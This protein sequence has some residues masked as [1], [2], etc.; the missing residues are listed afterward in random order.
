MRLRN[1]VTSR[2]WAIMERIGENAFQ[3]VHRRRCRINRKRLAAAQVA[4]PAA[5]VQ[6]HN[7]IRMRMREED[8]V[9][10]ANVFAQH[11]DAKFRRCVHD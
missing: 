3:I 2:P 7:V 4:K 9:Q 10:P 8:R 6:S 11:L 1:E 5:V